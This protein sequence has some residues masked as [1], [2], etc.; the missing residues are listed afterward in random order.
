MGHPNQSYRARAGGGADHQ[1]GDHCVKASPGMLV[2]DRIT[3]RRGDDRRDD[4]GRQCRN[5]TL[6]VEA[7]GD[8]APGFAGEVGGLGLV[9]VVFGHYPLAGL[10]DAGSFEAVGD[11]GAAHVQVAVDLTGGGGDEDPESRFRV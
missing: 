4:P 3:D 7:E 11:C 2:G 6:D 9:D 5:H 1:D 10:L 8:R